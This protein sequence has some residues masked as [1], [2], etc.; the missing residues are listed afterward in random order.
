M[1]PLVGL[2][3][4]DGWAA[5]NATIIAVVLVLIVLSVDYN[6]FVGVQAMTVFDGY[7]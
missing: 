5:D 2:E 3:H 6:S 4:V 1:E 7:F